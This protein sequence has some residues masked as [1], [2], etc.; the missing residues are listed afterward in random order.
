MFHVVYVLKSEQDDSLYIGYTSNLTRRLKEHD[1]GLNF[2]TKAKKP[3]RLIFF[4]SY[5]SE[6]DARRREKY[7]KTSTG[8]RIIRRM[9]KA[10]FYQISVEK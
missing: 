2:S 5:L 4:E 3:W 10:Y 7:L 9:L 1:L 8:S 6:E